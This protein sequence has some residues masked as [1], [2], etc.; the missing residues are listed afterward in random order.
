M[1]VQPDHALLRNVSFDPSVFVTLERR[2]SASNDI[3]WLP[4]GSIVAAFASG[5]NT[6]PPAENLTPFVY[7]E[8]DWHQDPNKHITMRLG[9]YDEPVA[10]RNRPL[11]LE[12]GIQQGS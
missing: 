8:K 9:W 2:Q 6:H 12:S 5:H 10:H 11:N 1:L 4:F 3:L 7:I